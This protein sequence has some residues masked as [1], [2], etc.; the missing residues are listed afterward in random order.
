[1]VARQL[2]DGCDGRLAKTRLGIVR[3]QLVGGHEG[4]LPDGLGSL[5][6]RA[7]RAQGETITTRRTEYLL[8]GWVGRRTVAAM[9]GLRVEND[10]LAETEVLNG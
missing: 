4:E 3:P 8:R 5:S 2:R 7:G 1:M 10:A 9:T 6:G